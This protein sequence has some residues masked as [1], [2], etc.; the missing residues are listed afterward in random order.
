MAN[1]GALLLGRRT[2]EDFYSY[3]PHQ[4]DN[5]FTQVLNNTQKYVASTTLEE[6]LPWRSSILLEGDAADAVTGSRSSRARI[7]WCWAAARWSS[8]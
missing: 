1:S 4:T 6:P 5:P 2:Y 3:W 8:R 7:W